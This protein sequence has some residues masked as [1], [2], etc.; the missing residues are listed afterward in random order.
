MVLSKAAEALQS[1]PVVLVSV[2]MRSWHVWLDGSEMCHKR[3]KPWQ[4]RAISEVQLRCQLKR[5]RRYLAD[6]DIRA[7][8]SQRYNRTRRNLN[9]LPT[10]LTDDSAM[11]AAAMMGDNRMPN[12]G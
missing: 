7:R 4:M 11:A 3:T 2:E 9:A 12:T 5:G 10:T 1:Y 6:S 8:D